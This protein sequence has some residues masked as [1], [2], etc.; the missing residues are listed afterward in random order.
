MR[1][2]EGLGIGGS[3]VTS[4]VLCVEYSAT[5]HREYVTALFHLPLNL[6]HVSMVG[7]SYMLRNMDHFQLAISLPIFLLVPLRWIMMESPKW[8]LDNG[9]LLD[10]SYGLEK[11]NRQ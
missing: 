10:L 3:V 9:K 8:L 4:F 5:V 11:F 7:V 1:F 6:G 2:F